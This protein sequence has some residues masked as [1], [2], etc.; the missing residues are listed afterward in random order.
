[1]MPP[2]SDQALSQLL[3]R[4]EEEWR[5]LQAQRC[6]LQEAAL[7]DAHSQLNEAQGALRRLQE[8]F[9]YNLQVLEE[10][11]LELERYDAAFAQAR[12]LEEARQAEVSELRVEAARLRQALTLEARRREDL[13]Q[14]HQLKLQEHRL[15]LERVHSDKNSEMD[16][17]REQ[18]EHLKWM[19]ERKLEELDGELALQ[20]QELLLEFES[21]MQKREHGFRLQAD[22]MS[23]VVLTHEL[24]VKLLNKELA[25]V[26]EAAAQ[27]AESLRSAEASNAGLEGELRRS[28]QELRDLA[29]AKDARI[30]DLEGKLDCVQLSRKKEE[31]AFRRKHEEL[32]HL[33]RERDA[34]L[35]AVK[36]A[37]AE[38]L[39]A[40]E[41]RAQELQARCETLELRL[42]RA[43]AGKAD[44]LKSKDAAADKL[45]ED[46][47]ALRSGWDAQ[48][49]QLSK[50][51]VAKDLYIQS[52]QEGEVELKAH[53]A[54]CQQDIGRYKQQLSEAVERERCLE[55]EKA[56]LELDW[57]QRCD[58]VERDHYRKS[59]DLI[60]A[61]TEARDQVAAKLQETERML[62][63]QEVVLKAL[64]LERDQAMQAL[65]TRGLLPEREVQLLL[66]HHEE[67]IRESFPSSEI[68]R[69][70]EQN[71][72]LRRAVAEMRKEM[73]TLSD[74]VLPPAPSGGQV[75]D[76][77][78][79]RP[80]PEAAAE[81]PDHIMVLE[82]EIQNL[83]HKFK[84]LEEQVEDVFD[85]LK[86]S[87]SYPDSQPSVHTSAQVPAGAVSAGG[88]SIG[89]VLGRLRD[90]AQLV[91][92]LVAR[93]KQKVLQRP[94]DA[95]TVQHELPREVDQLHLEVSELRGQ[96][97][98][99]EGRLGNRPRPRALDK[100][101]LG[102]QVPAD[103]GPTGTEDQGPQPPQT[104]SVPRLQRKLKEAARK[105]LR[106]CLEKEQLLEMG[107]RLRAE[108]GH[109]APGKPRH[110]PLPTPEAGK[111]NVAPEARLGQLQPHF[112]AQVLQA[113]R[114]TVGFYQLFYVYNSA[115]LVGT[116]TC[117]SR[118]PGFTTR[119]ESVCGEGLAAPLAVLSHAAVLARTPMQRG[120]QDSNN[121]KKKCFS[122]CSGKVQPCLAQTVGRSGPPQGWTAGALAG[123]GQRQHTISTVTCRSAW[124]KEN[125]SPEPRPAQESH[126]ESSHPS[127]SP[128]SV[129]SG[130][131]QDMWKLLDLRS[132]PSGLT[133]QNDSAP[134]EF[135]ARPVADSLGH[136]DRSPVRTRAA[137]AIQGM[138]VEA[139]AKAKPARPSRAPPAK[140]K[141]CQRPPKIRNYNLKD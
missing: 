43:E 27:A 73:E 106:L 70:Q 9:V 86:R 108:L 38:Q 34:V 54:R 127:G 7:Q 135:T 57:R 118:F 134:V 112:A 64:T 40:L 2:P 61:L 41:A 44:A 3:A 45:R 83:K 68:Q 119:T 92:F 55:R 75:S 35:A 48:I 65:R 12:G 101:A 93:L 21:E 84:A 49:A 99:L 71:R 104:L 67:E 78:Q 50:E 105:I 66:R 42:R 89:L 15:E 113:I 25:A 95:D 82:T 96:V 79:P 111:Q 16:Q 53:L 133:S 141:G 122:E 124:Q 91:D 123:S 11:D 32:D 132:S 103:Q 81:V 94:L 98:E 131:L 114:S 22:S 30:K 117:G 138:K 77:E 80:S 19:L 116:N 130:P 128:S 110:H 1:M 74:H 97:A 47:L 121:T 102:R 33:A 109:Q 115:E 4:K 10:R 26:K 137:F 140:T 52:L 31:E 76:T 13:Q 5:E 17:Q 29:A 14:Q 8:D 23:N 62:R 36:G 59:E 37:H 6:Q 69:L 63:D 85:P 56:Q 60:R 90:R 100:V 139:H 51:M 24:K 20:R 88:A 107:N 87:S 129:A 58:G 125:R 46:A 126:K 18:Y 28:G 120:E 136:P 39:R 72:S